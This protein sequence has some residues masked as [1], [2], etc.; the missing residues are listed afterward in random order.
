MLHDKSRDKRTDSSPI[1][2]SR[3]TGRA[4][5]TDDSE[6]NFSEELKQIQNIYYMWGRPYIREPS[7]RVTNTHSQINIQTLNVLY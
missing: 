7:L 3:V 5:T 1:L 6:L 2:I 4:I